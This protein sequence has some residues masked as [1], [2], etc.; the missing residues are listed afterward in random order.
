MKFKY[1]IALFIVGT[2]I[3]IIVALFKIIH[4]ELG[5]ITGNVLLTIGMLLQII[6]GIGFLTKIIFNKNNEFLNR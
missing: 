2:L 6:S 4:F 1:F 5:A 3:T